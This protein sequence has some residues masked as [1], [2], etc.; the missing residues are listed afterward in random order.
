MFTMRLS[1]NKER[2]HATKVTSHMAY[3]ETVKTV[4][5]SMMISSKFA[6]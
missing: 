2:R 1:A 3:T 4:N 6:R 5:S